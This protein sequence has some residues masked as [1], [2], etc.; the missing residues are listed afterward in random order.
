MN[1][2]WEPP[3]GLLLI[4]WSQV[5]IAI[6]A[7]PPDD[8]VKRP[9]MSRALQSAH[10]ALDDA[11]LAAVKEENMSYRGEDHFHVK[12]TSKDPRGDP[13]EP[14][15]DDWLEDD[16]YKPEDRAEQRERLYQSLED[17]PDYRAV[18]IANARAQAAAVTGPTGDQVR[19]CIEVAE[20]VLR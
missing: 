19:E 12:D 7:C 15:A 8:T 18:A 3:D 5:R 17:G 4:A 14:V 13:P 1:A 6:A 10:V 20:R 16:D 9:I 11:R 2:D